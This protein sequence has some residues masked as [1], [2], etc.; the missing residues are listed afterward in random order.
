MGPRHRRGPD[1]IIR[2]AF[3]SA[4]VE[5]NVAIETDDLLAVQGVVAAVLAV[6]LS[7]ALALAH[8]RPDIVLRPLE[9]A[10]VVRRIEA[11]TDSAAAT[12]PQP[13]SSADYKPSRRNSPAASS[14]HTPSLNGQR[15]HTRSRRDGSLQP[16]NLDL[17]LANRRLHRA[18]TGSR[19]GRLETPARDV[20]KQAADEIH[21]TPG[22]RPGSGSSSC[23]R[24]RSLVSISPVF[25][26]S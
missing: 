11:V 19:R 4:G 20:R 26:S 15:T 24:L 16:A 1:A 13:R 23:R 5:P 25:L 22:S 2:R 12:P 17:E 3:A 10:H 7:P 6:T 18:E 8:T 21:R 14:Q 9:E